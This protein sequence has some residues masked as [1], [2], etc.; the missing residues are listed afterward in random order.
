[1][2]RKLNTDVI[3]LPI[4]YTD[5]DGNL[6]RIAEISEIMGDDEEEITDKKVAKNPG[7]VITT[8]LTRKIIRLGDIEKVTPNIVK[9]LFIADRDALLV[10]IRK[11]SA[12]EYMQ[13]KTTCPNCQE[14]DDVIVDLDNLNNR[15]WEEL[16]EEYPELADMERGYVPFEL[17]RG[18]Y[19]EIKPKDMADYDEDDLV[20]GQYILHKKGV[21]RFPKGD[22]EE[23]LSTIVRNN[24][25]KANTA[26]LTNCIEKLGTLRMVDTKIVKTDMSR[27]DREYLT[28]IL[29]DFK[30]GPNLQRDVDCPFCRYSHTVTLE[31]PYFF[32]G[33]SD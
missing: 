9:N 11:L 6:H 17:Q 1:M 5:E 22:V 8:L 15:T 33:I 27:F 30:C 29:R 16:M 2:A 23:R 13:F 18:V 7:N 31:L 26:L 32:T 28:K 24:A 3:E 20:D 21:I 14:K 4:G 12:G 10:A 25:G 19:E